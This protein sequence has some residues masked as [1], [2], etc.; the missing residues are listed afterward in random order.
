[1]ERSQHGDAY[2]TTAYMGCTASMGARPPYLAVFEGPTSWGMVQEPRAGGRVFVGTTWWWWGGVAVQVALALLLTRWT[3]VPHRWTAKSK[4]DEQ[5]TPSEDRNVGLLSQGF[6]V[7]ELPA[8]P[9]LTHRPTLLPPSLALT[10]GTPQVGN[11]GSRTDKLH[12]CQW[13]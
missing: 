4:K 10:P 13:G 7:S 6:Q 9:S 12:A 3:L 8:T 11:S 2:W 5:M 1:M